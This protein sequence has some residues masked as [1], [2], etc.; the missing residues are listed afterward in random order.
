MLEIR[1]VLQDPAFRNARSFK[2]QLQE[3]LIVSCIQ[4]F[5][6]PLTGSFQYSNSSGRSHLVTTFYA[7]GLWC[8][9]VYLGLGQGQGIGGVHSRAQQL[10]AHRLLKGGYIQG[11]EDSVQGRHAGTAPWGNTQALQQDRV[12]L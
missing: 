6:L 4:E 12:I 11:F 9:K 10:L 7:L 8:R 3:R 2:S 1:V 5:G